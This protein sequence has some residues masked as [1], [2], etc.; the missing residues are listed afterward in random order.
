MM[1]KISQLIKRLILV[2]VYCHQYCFLYSACFGLQLSKLQSPVYL[3]KVLSWIYL[4]LTVFLIL[5][6]ESKTIQ[7]V[8]TPVWVMLSFL[9]YLQKFLATL[10]QEQQ[11]AWVLPHLLCVL[12]LLKAL[13]LKFPLYQSSKG[14]H[15]SHSSFSSWIL[16]LLFFLWKLIQQVCHRSLAYFHSEIY[17]LVY[18]P[19]L[20]R[21]HC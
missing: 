12:H 5:R 6:L 13:I 9:L 8:V 3:R 15:Y 7:P 21:F 1:D 2:S 11:E 18:C 10:F 19:N 4:H 14:H 16:D 20:L 17:S